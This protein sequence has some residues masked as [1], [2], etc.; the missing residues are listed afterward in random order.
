VVIGIVHHQAVAAANG[1]F[2]VAIVPDLVDPKQALQ[3]DQFG[4]RRYRGRLHGRWA[5]DARLGSGLAAHL[6]QNGHK[7]QQ[8]Q[9]VG[10]E[11]GDTRWA[12][13]KGHGRPWT[14][15]P[16]LWFDRPLAKT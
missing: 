7:K 1:Q 16:Q 6:T 12:M 15:Q 8:K 9:V 13:D 11:D 3:P 5:R 2:D 10:G 4:C 14:Q